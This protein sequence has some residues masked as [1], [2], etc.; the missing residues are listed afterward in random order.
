MDE[1]VKF[2]LVRNDKGRQILF[3]T[4]TEREFGMDDNE[5]GKKIIEKYGKIL[6][7]HSDLYIVM[8]TRKMRSVSPGLGWNLITDLIEHNEV[9]KKN[10]RKTAILMI[11]KIMKKYLIDPILCVYS[12]AAP[13]EFFEKNDD[14]LRYVQS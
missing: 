9:A 10:V 11:S 12:F 6:T 4:F 1:L 14:A 2:K 5:M 7:K 3:V 13:T 8:D